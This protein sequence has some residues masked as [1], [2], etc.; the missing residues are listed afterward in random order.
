MLNSETRCGI[1]LSSLPIPSLPSVL[2]TCLPV[3]SVQNGL[4]PLE[5]ARAKNVDDE[6]CQRQLDKDYI[7]WQSRK[8][9]YHNYEDYERVI[10][11]LRGYSE[12]TA[13]L[14]SDNVNR[15]TAIDTHATVS[16]HSFA[17]HHNWH[18]K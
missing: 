13:T 7:M 15:L 18:N 10:D 3:I 11:L 6:R 1:S 17:F 8:P 12:E 5:V 14:P 2:Y 9:M 4:T 16:L